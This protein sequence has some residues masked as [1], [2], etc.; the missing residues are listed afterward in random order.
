MRRGARRITSSATRA[1]IECPARLKRSAG[2]LSSTPRA[3]ASIE[4]RRPYDGTTQ[5]QP[6]NA[7]HCAAHTASSQ[8]S[9]GSRTTVGCIIVASFPQRACVRQ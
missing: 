4:S 1:P 6:D 2:T 3:M 7:A 9:P 8:S 5:R